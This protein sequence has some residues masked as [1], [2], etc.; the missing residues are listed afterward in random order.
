MPDPSEKNP[1][2]EAMRG[3]ST[4]T[5]FGLELVLPAGAG[6]WL[7]QRFGTVPWLSLCGL[8]LGLMAGTYHLYLAVKSETDDSKRRK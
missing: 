1:W 5:T 3:V 4:V 6:Y 8:L 2:V 7:D